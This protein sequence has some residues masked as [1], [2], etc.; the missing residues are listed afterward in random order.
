MSMLKVIKSPSLRKRS[1]LK[2]AEQLDSSDLK[3]PDNIITIY[4]THVIWKDSYWDE[5]EDG[6]M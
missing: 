5:L 1:E 6:M 4:F 3:E 2:W